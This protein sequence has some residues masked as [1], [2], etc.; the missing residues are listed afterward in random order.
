M[1][2]PVGALSSAVPVCLRSSGGLVGGVP[3]LPNATIKTL[4][5][6][7]WTPL[8]LRF[9]SKAP[10]LRTPRVCPTQQSTAD[11]EKGGVKKY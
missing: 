7:P 10:N 9:G 11:Q 5:P 3:S 4:E 6:K 1:P 2:A 8:V